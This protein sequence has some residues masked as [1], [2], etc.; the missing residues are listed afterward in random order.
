MNNAD[1]LSIHDHLRPSFF[2]FFFPTSNLQYSENLPSVSLGIHGLTLS[3]C[4][5]IQSIHSLSFT[6]NALS[7]SEKQL[8]RSLKVPQILII[9]ISKYL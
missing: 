2:F 7:D 4:N 3:Y 9:T 5:H 6:K 1:S 8:Q